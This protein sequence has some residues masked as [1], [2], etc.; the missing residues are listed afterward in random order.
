MEDAHL[1]TTRTSDDVAGGVVAVFRF[2]QLSGGVER[3]QR[4]AAPLKVVRGQGAATA[5]RLLQVLR[6]LEDAQR[7][8]VAHHVDGLA[9]RVG[10]VVLQQGGVDDALRVAA[11]LLQGRRLLGEGRPDVV[12]GGQRLAVVDAP[13]EEDRLGDAPEGRQLGAADAPAAHHHRHHMPGAVVGADAHEGLV[14]ARPEVVGDQAALPLDP[15]ML[16]LLPRAEQPVAG[17][18]GLVDE[19]IPPVGLVHEQ[20]DRVLQASLPVV[21]H[22]V[23]RWDGVLR[24]LRSVRQ[25]VRGDAPL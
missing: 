8:V 9:G 11:H 23:P 3:R 13:A 19:E 4:T 24:R 21:P 15:P 12:V 5:Q 22:G 20:E 17:A 2:G 25:A 18:L 6:H 16:L 14:A 1:L 10:A 7:R